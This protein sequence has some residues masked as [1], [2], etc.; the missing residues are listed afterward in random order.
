MQRG[1][2]GVEERN[3]MAFSSVSLLSPSAQQVGRTWESVLALI[4]H[5]RAEK[6]AGTMRNEQ[7]PLN[8]SEDAYLA[9]LFA[10]VIM[11][12]SIVKSLWRKAN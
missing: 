10:R 7:S 12:K 1:V 6:M 11:R 8:S 2:H 5:R 9:N 3:G 4:E